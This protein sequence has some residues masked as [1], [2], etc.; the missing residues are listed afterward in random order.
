MKK[1]STTSIHTREFCEKHGFD[2]GIQ[3]VETLSRNGRL[4]VR[5][6][7]GKPEEFRLLRNCCDGVSEVYTGIFKNPTKSRSIFARA[8]AASEAHYK[9]GISEE[10]RVAE[11]EE[12]DRVN[13][14]IAAYKRRCAGEV[15]K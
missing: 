5:G 14:E 2:Q 3:F 4:Y 12:A 10:A 15:G 7:F 1:Y 11:V 8:L 13:A 9:A 6:T